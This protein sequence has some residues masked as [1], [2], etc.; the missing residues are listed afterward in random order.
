MDE[1]P[2]EAPSFTVNSC[3]DH[4]QSRSASRGKKKKNMNAVDHL[5]RTA[6]WFVDLIGF[7]GGMK[8]EKKR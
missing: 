5:I 1:N 8:N 6:Q 7:V 4:P 2:M 3:S